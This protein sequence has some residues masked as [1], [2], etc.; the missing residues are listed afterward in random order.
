MTTPLTLIQYEEAEREV[1]RAEARRGLIIHAVITALVW[2]ILIPVNVY[3]APEF[4][5]SAFAVAGMAIG[6]GVH[7]MF[8][9]RLLE[10][11]IDAHQRKVER[12]ATMKAA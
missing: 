11:S 2:A 7:Y 1:A 5:W 12:W 3:I 10:R 4:P 8:G 6:L 9:V